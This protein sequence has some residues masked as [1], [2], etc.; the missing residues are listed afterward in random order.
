M[1]YRLFRINGLPALKKDLENFKREWKEG[2]D[3]VESSLGKFQHCDD[4]AKAQYPRLLDAL[5]KELFLKYPRMAHL[6]I[7]T[8]KQLEDAINEYGALSF[9]IEPDENN[10]QKMTAYILD[11]GG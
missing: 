10:I 5:E 11:H 8:G 9:C 4:E 7:D 2:Y 6:E 1:T 3:K